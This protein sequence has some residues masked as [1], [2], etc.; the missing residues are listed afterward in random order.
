MIDRI[1]RLATYEAAAATQ[2]GKADAVWRSAWWALT[3]G[4]A[5]VPNDGTGRPQLE[6]VAQITGTTVNSVRNRGRLGRRLVTLGVSNLDT[7]PPRMVLAIP[8]ELL[9]VAT[10]E[11]AREAEAEGLSLREFSAALTG[12][13]WSDTAGGASAEKIAE[14]LSK[15]EPE[16][17]EKALGKL[18]AARLRAVVSKG[19]ETESRNREREHGPAPRP[20]PHPL[21]G[22]IARVAA[23]KD[24]ERA[25]R[26]AREAIEGFMLDFG[27]PD[28]GEQ[29]HVRMM[30]VGLLDAIV[31]EGDP[32]WRAQA[33][34]VS[35]S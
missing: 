8:A 13:E 26:A 20:H 27:E 35:E 14:T 19:L 5:E 32:N 11:R 33:A 30:A 3:L 12:R 23:W 17:I 15:A 34:E 25:L 22:L 18:P 2:R 9:T 29:A 6:R 24:V 7:L 16:V 10:V 1:E 4:L 28:E 31:G 21:D